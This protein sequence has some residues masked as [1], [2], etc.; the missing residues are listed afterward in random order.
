YDN[1]VE[2]LN[3]II[4]NIEKPPSFRQL[5]G[6][7]IRIKQKEDTNTFLKYLHQNTTN[8]E[9]KNIY[10]FLFKLTSL[11]DSERKLELYNEIEQIKKDIDQL[12]KL[13][14]FSNIDDLSERIRIVQKS[15]RELEVKFKTL[16]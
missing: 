6:K 14:N 9:Y 3:E 13:H 10:E 4:F 1:Y 16:I 15:V 8:A 11:E 5:I 12:I 2:K 7:F